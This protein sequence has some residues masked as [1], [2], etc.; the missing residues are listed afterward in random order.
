MPEA[1]KTNQGMNLPKAT[2]E[3]HS[4]YW[5]SFQNVGK[6]LLMSLP[7]R[8][9]DLATW[10]EPSFPSLPLPV[11]PSPS[12]WPHVVRSVSHRPGGV[13]KLD[14]LILRWGSHEPLPPSERK[15]SAKPAG[16]ICKGHSWTADG[17]YL[18]QNYS[19]TACG[20]LLLSLLATHHE[21]LEYPRLLADL[22][23][24]FGKYFLFDLIFKID[25]YCSDFASEKSEARTIVWLLWTYGS[26]QTSASVIVYKEHAFLNK[27]NPP[28]SGL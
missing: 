9:D 24:R 22:A 14:E 2:L 20:H 12:P 1:P 16:I 11:Y 26:G 23:G 7:I 25:S 19:C 3:N 21:Y 18:A 10:A 6:R 15:R 8:D 5:A 27:L 17:R 28:S 4:V 13:K